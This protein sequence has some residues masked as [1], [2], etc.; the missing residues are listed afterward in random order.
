MAMKAIKVDIDA[1]AL[2]TRAK[3]IVGDGWTM[4]KVTTVRRK[5]KQELLLENGVDIDVIEA[6]TEESPSTSIQ[7]RKSAPDVVAGLTS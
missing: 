5:I 6:S 3:K 4:L 1:A 2:K 7:V